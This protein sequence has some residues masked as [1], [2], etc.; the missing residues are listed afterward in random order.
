MDSAER[1]RTIIILI[2][3]F[4]PMT[5]LYIL[6]IKVLPGPTAYSPGDRSEYCRLGQS[7]LS[8]GVSPSTVDKN[9]ASFV[10]L[11]TK[12]IQLPI[13]PPLIAFEQYC[14]RA[15][16]KRDTVRGHIPDSPKYLDIARRLEGRSP[17]RPPR[18]I[19]WVRHLEAASGYA[20]GGRGMSREVTVSIILVTFI[21][22]DSKSVSGTYELPW[23]P[24][25]GLEQP[26]LRHHMSV[27]HLLS[28]LVQQSERQQTP[29]TLR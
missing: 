18:T 6:L 8:N 9:P 14:R 25:V 20:L 11:D 10:D 7:M 13:K 1:R 27:S 19:V 4:L 24:S 21:D 15:P 16:C 17:D 3:V 5:A 23:N 12:V 22:I 2:A 26:G 28:K 29:G